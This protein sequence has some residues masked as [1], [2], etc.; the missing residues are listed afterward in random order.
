M[1]PTDLALLHALG[2]PTMSPDARHAVVAASHPDLDEDAYRGALWRVP[3]DGSAPPRRL[4]HGWHDSAPQYSP[5]GRWLAFL[6]AAQ[7]GKPQVHV[8]PTDGGEPRRV[9]EQALGSGPPAWS[10]DS[11][12]ICYVARVPDEGRYGTRDGV[13]PDREPPRRITTLQFRVDDLGFLIDRRSHVFVVDPFAGDPGSES[14]PAQVTSGDYDHDDV[15]WSP[16]GALLTFCAARHDERDRDLARDVWV[17]APDGSGLCRVSR[18]SRGGLE[19]SRP[20]F[21]PDGAHVLFVA[22]DLGPSGRA[23]FASQDGVWS[24]PADGSAEA[25]R[26]TD[27]ERYHVAA[28]APLEPTADGVLFAGE[29]RGAV[30]LLLAPYDGAEPRPVLAGHRQVQGCAARDGVLVATVAEPATAGELIAVRDGA[31]RVLT[32]FGAELASRGVHPMAEI[33]AT[34]PDGHPVHGWVV[35]PEGHGPHPVLLMIHGGPFAQYGWRLFDEA[36]VCAGAGFAVVL[37]NPRGSSGYGRAHGR[38][39]VGDVGARSAPDLLALLD[40]ALEAP[41]LDAGRVGVLGGSYG[42]YMTTWL[43]AHTDRFRAA[44]SER[45]LNVSDSFLGSSDFGWVL[46]DE[47]FGTDPE[48]QAEQSPLTYAGK[49]DTPLLIIHSEQDWRCPVEQAQRLY[50]ALKMR[51]AVETELLLFPGEGHELSRSGLP[52]HRV[53]RFEAILDWW[54]RH[55]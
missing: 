46:V 39:I 28:A 29:H 11:T 40:A 21:A 8:M 5:D 45:A 44:I 55:L 15:A 43:A 31:E 7:G 37:G 20:R 33:D 22:A 2:V 52:S 6:R 42:G 38:H 18:V 47:L 23:F 35:R 30:D 53:A 27:P 9:A 13:T 14:Q 3:T 24:A 4:T 16:D 25:R 1:K 10:P 48:R 54:S 17:C 19:A 34:A 32:S 49:I 41:D 51:G 36:Q 12:R 26:L 50:V